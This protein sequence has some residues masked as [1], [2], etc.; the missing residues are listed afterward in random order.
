MRTTQKL[1]E[2]ENTQ[3]QTAS[4]TRW[5]KT[6]FETLKNA[7]ETNAGKRLQKQLRNNDSTCK[8]NLENDQ[9]TSK[10]R[11]EHKLGKAEKHQTNDVAKR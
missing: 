8:T 11:T 6:N 10:I 9:R 7:S 1:N 2:T 4:Q 3:G 5:A